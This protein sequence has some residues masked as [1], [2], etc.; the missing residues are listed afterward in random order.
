[1]I[2][3]VGDRIFFR[4]YSRLMLEIVI[5]TTAKTAFTKSYKLNIE[6]SKDGYCSIRAGDIWSPTAKLS[7]IDLENEW[8]KQKRK[9][10]FESKKFT[11]DEIDK[12]YNLFNK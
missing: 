3:K 8:I 7:N 4:K 12:I 10:W 5:R 6:T 1:M 9:D 2:L 11:Q